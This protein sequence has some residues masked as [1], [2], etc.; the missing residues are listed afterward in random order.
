MLYVC[1]L[2]RQKNREYSVKTKTKKDQGKTLGSKA[3]ASKST[4]KT[5][6]TKASAKTKVAVATPPK[7]VKAAAKPAPKASPAKKPASKTSSQATKSVA[8]TTPKK[9]TLTKP[10]TPA[11]TK[12]TTP[13]KPLAATKPASAKTPAKAPTVLIQSYDPYP[14]KAGEVYMDA[15]QLIH[16]RAL[17]DNWKRELMQEVDHTITE[18][19]EASV[20]FLADPNDRATQEETFNLE[21]RTRDRERKLIRKIE[22]ALKRIDAKD[23]GY[24]ELCGVEI[25]IRR[26]E[27]RPTAVLCIDCKTLD[28]IRERRT[29]Q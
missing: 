12:A 28:E 7:T 5:A 20:T 6:K 11:K 13:N 14:L 3:A 16:F 22:E 26:L 25:G 2:D 8:K 17:L 19:K 21:L 23:Y 18:M 24:C 4:T 9:T 10:K 29:A 1:T 27:A 15:K